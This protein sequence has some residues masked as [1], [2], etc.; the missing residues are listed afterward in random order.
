M[1]CDYFP[2]DFYFLQ[3]AQEDPQRVCAD[4]IHYII[5]RIAIAIT[6][7]EN[8]DLVAITSCLVQLVAL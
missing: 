7:I 3:K 6:E 4:R 5:K 1:Y 2:K 8:V